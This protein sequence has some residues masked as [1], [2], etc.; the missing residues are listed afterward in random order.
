M[1]AAPPPP[2]TSADKRPEGWHIYV[3]AAFA[4]IQLHL[5]G[6]SLGCLADAIGLSGS[7]MIFRFELER[8]VSPLMHT[9]SEPNPELTPVRPLVR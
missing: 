7:A 8:F 5:A 9:H 1:R 3:R 6:L 4:S 2:F